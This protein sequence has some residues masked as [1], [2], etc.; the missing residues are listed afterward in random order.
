MS[1]AVQLNYEGQPIRPG[2]PYGGRAEFPAK[3][4]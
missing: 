4:P 1:E 2:E 3:K